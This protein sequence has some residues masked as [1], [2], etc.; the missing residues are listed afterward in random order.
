MASVRFD[1]LRTVAFGS[2]T[3]SY[4]ALGTPT[5]KN[6]RLVKIVNTT[7]ADMLVSFDGTT[8]NDIIPAGGFALYDFA[9][10]APAT[11]SSSWFVLAIATQ[12]Y[13]KYSTAPTLG[14]VWVVGIYST[15]V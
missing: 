7:D 4:T 10:N 6:M 3:G 8:D 15:G 13:V 1:A 2:I 14:A 5:T 11:A 9:T 12:I